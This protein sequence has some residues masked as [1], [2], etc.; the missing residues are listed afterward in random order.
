LHL[1]CS[2]CHGAV[3]LQFADWRQDRPTLTQ[4]WTCPY[5]KTR[6]AGGFPGRLV[7]VTRQTGSATKH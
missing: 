2:K 5:C 6:N 7:W 4:Q 3:E 1:N